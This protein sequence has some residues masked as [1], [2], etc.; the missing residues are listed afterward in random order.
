MAAF[1]KLHEGSDWKKNKNMDQ[2]IKTL[3]T[4]VKMLPAVKVHTAE[5]VMVKNI[6]QK[7]KK[8][9]IDSYIL[10][11]GRHYIDALTPSIDL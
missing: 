2:N 9:F 7:Y 10:R 11:Y 6:F 1:Q 5:P 3:R 4:R 8:F